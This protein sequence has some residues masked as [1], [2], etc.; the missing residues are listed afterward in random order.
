M[1]KIVNTALIYELAVLKTYVEPLLYSVDED[2]IYYEDALRLL[3]ILRLV[4][5]IPSENIPN[6][7]ILREFIG[8]SCFHN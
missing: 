2:S 8:G 3:N 1:K 4:L 7:S 6:D 5:P